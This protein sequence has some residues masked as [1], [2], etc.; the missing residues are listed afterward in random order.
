[1]RKSI[2]LIAA[3]CMTSVM[4]FAQK[5]IRVSTDKTDLVMKVSP[6]GRLY[7]VYLGDKMLNPSDYDNSQWSSAQASSSDDVRKSKN[8]NYLPIIKT[9]QQ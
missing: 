2:M 3:M 6:K 1:M 4:T 7:Q 9:I 8:K 5:T